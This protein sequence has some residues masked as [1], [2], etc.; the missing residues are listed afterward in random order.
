[1]IL[2]VAVLFIKEGLEEQFEYDFK[3][4]GQYIASI[5]G[6]IGHTLH[7]C[8]EQKNKYLLL[9]QWETLEDHTIGFR[10]SA[11][12]EHWKKLLHHYYEP[13]PIVEHFE[14]VNLATL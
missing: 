7:K 13:F 11:V 4:A 6:Y 9:V 8:V 3:K 1:M 10:Q 5:S 14:E 12:Y 2:E